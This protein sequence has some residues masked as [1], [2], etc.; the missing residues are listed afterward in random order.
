MV[1][2]GTDIGD[3]ADYVSHNDLG[4]AVLL[5]ALAAAGFTG[6]L[7]LASSMVV[8]GEG[9][10]ACPEHGVVRPP[11]RARARP[12]RRPLRAPVPGLR[13]PARAARRAGGRASR[14]RATCTP[15]P[16]SRRSICAPRSRARP[17]RPSRRCATTTS[18]VRGCRATRPTPASRASSARRLPPA[19]SRACSRTAASGAT[20][21]TCA[22]WR[23][24]TCWRS[25]RRSRCRARS[26]S[27][28]ARRARC[29]TWRDALTRAFGSD[30]APVVTGEW[31]AGD[32]RHVFASAAAAA[33]RLGFRAAE[34]FDAGMRE[35][36][37]A[38][39]RG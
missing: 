18:T 36:A 32:V 12:R 7:V 5:R 22:T 1:G 15:P 27:P 31:R 24:P 25:R 29:S 2:L 39:L 19:T 23:A 6:R 9:R 26:T 37:S 20:S 8:Y 21:S 30:R 16:R 17:A 34:D 28:A 35:F 10:Y 33:E 38:P 14:T 13:R 4:T 11:P 3:I